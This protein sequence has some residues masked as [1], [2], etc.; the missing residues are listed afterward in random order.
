MFFF[1]IICERSH[2]GF[3]NYKHAFKIWGFILLD[4]ITVKAL[5]SY[6][7]MNK[8][9]F[10]TIDIIGAGVSQYYGKAVEW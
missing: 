1:Y 6:T 3:F 5:K 10:N 7:S 2:P 9:R 4:Y 8:F